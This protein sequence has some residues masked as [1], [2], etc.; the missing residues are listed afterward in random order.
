VQGVSERISR[1]LRQQQVKVAFKPLRTLNSL[2]PRP[3]A[4]EKVDRPQFDHNSKISCH[5]HENATFSRNYTRFPQRA[6]DGLFFESR[7]P[8]FYISIDEGSSTSQNV[9]NETSRKIVSVNHA[10]SHYFSNFFLFSYERFAY[11][12]TLSPHC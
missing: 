8:T 9:L 6:L 7:V 11:I 4:Q 2:F 5:V 10:L 3:K 1:I 12:F